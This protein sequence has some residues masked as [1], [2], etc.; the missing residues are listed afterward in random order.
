MAIGDA[1]TSSP[2][3]SGTTTSSTSN[4]S[5]LSSK[6]GSTIAGNFQTFLTLLTTQL[7]N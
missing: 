5:S 7:Q 4:G 1:I 3:V 6:A 2:P